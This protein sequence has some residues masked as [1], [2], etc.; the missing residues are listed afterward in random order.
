MLLPALQRKTKCFIGTEAEGPMRGKRTLFVPGSCKPRQFIT[1]LCQVDD[2]IELI[3][4]GAGNDRKLNQQTIRLLITLSCCCKCLLTIE[5][6]SVE[7]ISETISKY[8]FFHDTKKVTI[9]SRNRNDDDYDIDRLYIKTIE[10][11]LIIWR[12]ANT[13]K[14]YKTQLNDPLF[15][16]DQYVE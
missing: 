1:A 5:A 6:D 13:D 15:E 10:A 2:A 9:V 12:S 11:D 16:Q 14:V 8:W 3:Y 7:L 4:Y